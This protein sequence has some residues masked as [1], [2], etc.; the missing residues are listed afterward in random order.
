MARAPSLYK[1]LFQWVMRSGHEKSRRGSPGGR[2][3]PEMDFGGFQ[4]ERAMG[5]EPTWPAWKAGALPLSYAR[6][7]QPL[8]KWIRRNDFRSGPS[9]KALRRRFVSSVLRNCDASH[10]RA[11][12]LMPTINTPSR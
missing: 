10:N 3:C 2:E 6:L 5:I 1:P 11:W 4:M 12:W 8:L 9:G 7:I